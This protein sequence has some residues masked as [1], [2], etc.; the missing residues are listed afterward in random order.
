MQKLGSVGK[1]TLAFGR[2]C[3]KNI[4]EPAERPLAV[5]GDK[6]AFAQRLVL[7][8]AYEAFHPAILLA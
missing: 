3:Q 5:D 2:E 7:N 6:Q 4:L 8:R 1:P